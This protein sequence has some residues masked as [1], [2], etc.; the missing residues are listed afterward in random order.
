MQS[1]NAAPSK[2]APSMASPP[3][4]ISLPKTRSSHV[5]SSDPNSTSA[6][7][8]QRLLNSSNSAL[9][10]STSTPSV[11]RSISPGSRASPATDLSS[12]VFGALTP[13]RSSP[14]ASEIQSQDDPRHLIR[15]SYVP[16]IAVRASSDTEEIVRL[17]GFRGG[18]RELLRPFGEAVQGK[19][20]VRD[21]I[22]ASRVWEDFAVRFVG[23][24]DG[25]EDP[26]TLLGRNIDSKANGVSKQGRQPEA[27][28]ATASRI[29]GDIDQIDEVVSRH[30]SY[31]EMM[32]NSKP[33]DYLTYKAIG[34]EL[35]SDT[36][37]FQT[38][39]LRRLLSGFPMSPH[40]TFS[41]PVACIIAISSRSSNPIEALRQLYDS[42]S[43][44]DQRYPLWVNKDYLRYYVLVHDEDSDDINKSTA[45]FEQMKRHFGLHCHLL[46]LRSSQCVPTDDDSVAMPR[47]EWTS[48][49]EELVEIESRENDDDV[50]NMSGCIYESDATA[51]KTFV[52]EMIT[53]SV[54]PFMERCVATWNDQVA[55]R[56]KGISGRFM[57]LSKK[58]TGFGSRSSSA[59]GG[60]GGGAGS[61]GSNYDALQG[62]YRPETPEAMMRKLADYAFM[63][64]DWKLAQ[65]TYDILRAD[66]SNDKAWKYHA[67]ANEMAAISTLLIPQPISSKTRSETLEQMLDSAAYSY[68]TRC[69]APYEALRSLAVAVELLRFR[70]GSWADA[71]ARWAIRLLEAKIL[72]PT[73]HALYTER[74]AAC[75][76]ARKGAGSE[77]WG[78]RRRK[79]ALW[80]VLAAN[81]WLDLD[82]RTQAQRCLDAGERVYGELPPE[83][84]HTVFEDVQAFVKDLRLRLRSGDGHAGAD[85]VADRTSDEDVAVEEEE[86]K[87]DHRNHRKSL[88]GGGISPFAG[89]DATS[90]SPLRTTFEESGGR[91]DSFQ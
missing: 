37:P 4:V 67:A 57:S 16:Q 73:G 48:A 5:Q 24:G 47:C 71:A 26:R 23:F 34:N 28:E 84:G 33:A 85:V 31:A 36:S 6:T 22:G 56:R 88:I 39:F 52:R 42:T 1:E 58:W 78:A 27:S 35:A 2:P 10:A 15:A 65:G 72:G 63:L 29:G 75:Y 86:E 3:S 74:V 38:L 49:A 83:V 41:H 87:L 30:L 77:R 89:M 45:L 62:F 21:S 76:G 20:T 66:F 79:A 81:A 32:S 40:E 90:L 12:S 51:L 11:S 8:P 18:L 17:K 25:L 59:G 43:G 64:R 54:I 61:S 44:G 91:D 13:G 7:L 70:G 82:K 80:S 46:R 19:V 14:L 55:S 68:L 9:Y 50:D 60:G 69:V 53:Q